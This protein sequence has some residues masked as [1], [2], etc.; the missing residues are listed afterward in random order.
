MGPKTR[1]T[2]D[3]LT[4]DP[5]S[6]RNQR[7]TPSI[8]RSMARAA[9]DRP[10]GDEAGAAHEGDSLA[11]AMDGALARHRRLRSK[12]TA[13]GTGGAFQESTHGVSPVCSKRPT[14]GF[15]RSRYVAMQPLCAVELL[16]HDGMG[17][18]VSNGVTSGH[19]CQ[20]RCALQS[21]WVFMRPLGK[22]PTNV[23]F[24]W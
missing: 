12:S 16:C 24:Q 6:P 21:P 10:S 8:G 15:A 3:D 2:I 23:S 11:G 5:R 13:P 7:V 17:K 19:R 22:L 20:R 14:R 9:G 18:T 4:S 1:R